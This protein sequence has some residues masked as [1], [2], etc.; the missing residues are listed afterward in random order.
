MKK[1]KDAIVKYKNEA[2]EEIETIKLKATQIDILMALF[3]QVYDEG[4]KTITISFASIRQLAGLR[5]AKNSE[6]ANMIN[7]NILNIQT[8]S[9]TN[10]SLDVRNVFI[11]SHADYETGSITL[12]VNPTCETLFNYLTKE[13][14]KFPLKE[15][16]SLRGKPAKM[17][18]KTLKQFRSTGRI[19]R[20]MEQIKRNLDIEPDR[21]NKYFI[22]DALTPAVERN[23]KY[24]ENLGI[25]YLH[26]DSTAPAKI[27]RCILTFKPEKAG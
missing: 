22:R 7:D 17:L 8:R 3:S 5:H 23:R 10:K 20:T 12:S 24:F 1:T 15:I 14:T 4:T 27:T 9:S 21:D 16:T 11:N 18:Y 26:E 6:L 13:Y 25:E 19:I 2:N